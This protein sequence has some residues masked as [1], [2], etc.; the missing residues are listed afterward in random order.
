MTA[1]CAV[2]CEVPNEE[3]RDTKRL[4]KEAEVATNDAEIGIR[5]ELS[6]VTLVE[7]EAESATKEVTRVDRELESVDRPVTRVENEAE[8]TTRL[9]RPVPAD[10]LRAA[11]VVVND[12]LFA[13]SLIESD[14]E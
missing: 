10:A 5:L 11:I 6:T 13:V 9:V 1:F 12:A 7:N 8:A 3:E 4:E 2:S 14:A